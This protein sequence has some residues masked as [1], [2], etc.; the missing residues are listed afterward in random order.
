MNRHAC[1]PDKNMSNLEILLPK[2]SD[3]KVGRKK[4]DWRSGQLYNCGK[5]YF[6]S[7]FYQIIPK[8]SVSCK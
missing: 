8:K 5:K 3:K 1:P 4:S 2:I 7:A 6:Q